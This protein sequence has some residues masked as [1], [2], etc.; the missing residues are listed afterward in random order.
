M[1][2]RGRIIAEGFVYNLNAKNK[3]CTIKAD[4]RIT[5]PDSIKAMTRAVQQKYFLDHY[6]YIFD[7]SETS[8][9]PSYEELMA[10]KNKIIGLR[11][12]FKRKIAIVT[13]HSVAVTAYLISRFAFHNG[14]QVM[15]FT[16][17]CSAEEWIK[18]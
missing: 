16:D 5:T 15:S 10:V 3:I 4:G 1:E 17:N 12:H 14:M 8:Y 13:S 2:T 7:L 6:N 18:S 11:S 9:N